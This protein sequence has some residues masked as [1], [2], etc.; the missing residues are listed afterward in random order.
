MSPAQTQGP[1]E[2]F[3]CRFSPINFQQAFSIPLFTLTPDSIGLQQHHRV[4]GPIPTDQGLSEILNATGFQ[5]H[6]M[7]K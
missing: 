2:G 5:A 4:R 7:S 1:S 6:R 3:G